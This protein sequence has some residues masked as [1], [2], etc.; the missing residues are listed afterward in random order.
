[1]KWQKLLKKAANKLIPMIGNKLLI[2]TNIVIELFRGNQTIIELLDKQQTV[3]I[4]FAVLGKLYLGW[5]FL[6]M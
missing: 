6:T 4:P 5:R 1:M 2:D 3:Y